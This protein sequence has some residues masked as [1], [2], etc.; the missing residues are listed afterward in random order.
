MPLPRPIAAALPLAPSLTA[1]ELAAFKLLGLG[2]DNRSIARH[3]S[4][5]ERTAKRH[6]TA[7][8]EK[9]GLESRL[10]AGLAAM[11]MNL[12]TQTDSAPTWLE[13]RPVDPHA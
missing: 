9:L 12:T 4:I 6:V 2:F 5:S 11:A 10:Q 8:L 1:R 3:L 7:I 13:D